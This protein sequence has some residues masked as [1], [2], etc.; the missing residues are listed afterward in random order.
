LFDR[1]ALTHRLKWLINF[2]TS[3]RVN[4]H[5][6]FARTIS[7]KSRYGRSGGARRTQTCDGTYGIF[8]SGT[9]TSGELMR[10]R[11]QRGGGIT[12]RR[13]RKTPTAELRTQ[14][15]GRRTPTWLGRPRRSRRRIPH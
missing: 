8:C 14:L 13:A 12:R 3:F 9:R 6:L 7:N 15:T 4:S 5:C 2:F 11:R 1:V 10:P